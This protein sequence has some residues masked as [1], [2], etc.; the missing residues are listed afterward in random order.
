MVRL[1]VTVLGGDGWEADID[2]SKRD[3]HR[4]ASEL[5]GF[6]GGVR[7]NCVEILEISGRSCFAPCLTPL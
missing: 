3:T 4:T 5:R 2:S 6:K 7:A 1:A